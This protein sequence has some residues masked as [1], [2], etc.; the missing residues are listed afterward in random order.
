MVKSNPDEAKETSLPIFIMVDPPLSPV[1]F[2]YS[3]S[4]FLKKNKP[5]CISVLMLQ[6]FNWEFIVQVV[7]W[8]K[9]IFP[10]VINSLGQWSTPLGS[11]LLFFGFISVEFYL[12]FCKVLKWGRWSLCHW[13]CDGEAAICFLSCTQFLVSHVSVKW[14][15]QCYSFWEPC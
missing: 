7:W 9:L 13:Y 6:S 12:L 8:W 2:S 5:K 10:W 3:I 4:L 1:F 11:S 14:I 15:L